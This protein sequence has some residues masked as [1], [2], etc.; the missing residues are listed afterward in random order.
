MP[1]DQPRAP[2]KKFAAF[3]GMVIGTAF[4]GL[5]FGLLAALIGASILEGEL[6]GFGGLVGAVAGMVIGYPIGVI[7]GIFVVNK[8]IHYRGSLLLGSLGSILGGAITIGLAEPLGLNLIPGLLWVSF[9]LAPPLLG[10]IGF[11]LKR[12]GKKASAE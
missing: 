1:Q 7:V 11:H 10:T 3:T 12:A 8:L 6:A 4:I 9:L 2:V 5:I